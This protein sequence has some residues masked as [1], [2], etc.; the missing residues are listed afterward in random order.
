MLLLSPLL[1]AVVLGGVQNQESLYAKLVPNPTGKNA[2]EDYLRAGDLVG[3][4][5]WSK[6]ETWLGFKMRQSQEHLSYDE[7][8]EVPPGVSPDMPDLLVRRVANERFG[9]VVDIVRVGNEKASYDPRNAYKF[10]TGLPELARFR[11][12]AKIDLNRAQVEFADGHSRQAVSDLLEGITF[13]QKIFGSIL[14]SSLVSV[15][16]QAI[17]LSGIQAH[18]G[19]LSYD[20]AKLIDKRSQEMIETPLPAAVVYRNEFA[21]MVNDLDKLID[22]PSLVL[23][24]GNT[25]MYGAALKSMNPTDRIQLKTM[26]SQSLQQRCG[27]AAERMSG[28][29][30]GWLVKG[31]AEDPTPIPNDMSVSNLALVLVNA[32]EGKGLQRQYAQ[33]IAKGRIQLRLL[34]LNAKVIEYHWL[35]N[36]WPTKMEEFAGKETAFDPFEGRPF[37]YEV[38]DNGYRLYSLGVPGLGPVEL[39][40]RPMAAQQSTESGHP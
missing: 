2:Y 16:N 36:R 38:K 39:K 29:E 18:L 33:A 25:E 11:T 4:D 27:E 7:A 8:P 1:A 14:I 24:D 13:S 9:G 17:A 5:Q 12:L 28:P 26:V 10:D 32:L 37:H 35:N 20:D 6:Y 19:Q 3:P 21:M 22:T 40:Y 31:P 23:S 15:G 34:R 30:S